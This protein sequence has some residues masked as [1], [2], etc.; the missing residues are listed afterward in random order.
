M[1]ITIAGLSGTG[2]STTAVE[3]AEKLGYKHYSMGDLQRKLAE[4]HGLDTVE[5]SKLEAK[6][7]KYD[8]ERDQILRE[9]GENEDDFIIDTWL[10]AHFIP[11][12]FKVFLTCDLDIRARRIYEETVR[13]ENLAGVDHKR[14]SDKKYSSV[15]EAKRA[16][17]EKESLNRERWIRYYGF[18]F[19]DEKNY[20][21]VLD[22][23]G[24]T[25]G[26][27]VDMIITNVKSR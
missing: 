25:I 8:H 24:L 26:E 9:L 6:D 23:T 1:I 3:L 4:K 15:D 20:D 13:G 11:H 18:D 21:M 27:T 16:V 17:Q 7:P 10:G 5:F 19:M 2:K 12:A 14:F 22:T